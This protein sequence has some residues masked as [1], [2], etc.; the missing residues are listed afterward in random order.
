MPEGIEIKKEVLAMSKKN[1][2]K[3]MLEVV[4]IKIATRDAN[5]ACPYLTYQP[6]LP[7]AVKKLKK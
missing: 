3:K 1:A 2:V 5:V 7:E 4:A 6:T